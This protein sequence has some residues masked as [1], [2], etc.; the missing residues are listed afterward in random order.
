MVLFWNTK[1]E[2]K[3]IFEMH[4]KGRYI[5]QHRWQW[6]LARK[7]IKSYRED[8][9]TEVQIHNKGDQRVHQFCK[10]RQWARK[11]RIWIP[12]WRRESLDLILGRQE[13]EERITWLDFR[14]L[15]D[16]GGRQTLCFLCTTKQ[17]KTLNFEKSTVVWRNIFLVIERSIKSIHP[18]KKKQ[19]EEWESDLVSEHFVNTR[20][21]SSNWTVVMIKDDCNGIICFLKNRER[22]EMALELPHKDKLKQMG[23]KVMK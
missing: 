14:S 20:Q 2:A 6:Q 17:I 5:D 8:G 22:L 19:Y 16:G 10:R 7:I 1:D 11:A 15:R 3:V 18:H 12:E 4:E 21:D 23:W 9:L 13:M